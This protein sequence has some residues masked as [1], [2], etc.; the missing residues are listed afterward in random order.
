MIIYEIDST[1]RLGPPTRRAAPR[2]LESPICGHPREP[3]GEQKGNPGEPEASEMGNQAGEQL[4]VTT[5]CPRPESAEEPA[6]PATAGRRPGEAARRRSPLAIGGR[7]GASP[8]WGLGHLRGGKLGA[9]M[10]GAFT[11]WG[12]GGDR[13]GGGGDGG[14]AAEE[15]RTRRWG[16]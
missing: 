6:A 2:G 1:H 14:D 10:A 3:T 13:Q 15:S 8:R 9:A 12:W 16:F 11:G 5:P 4:T 7:W